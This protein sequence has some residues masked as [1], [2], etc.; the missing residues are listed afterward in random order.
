MRFGAQQKR[1]VTK[2]IHPNGS[3]NFLAVDGS[4]HISIRKDFREV[5]YG[6][7]R[8]DGITIAPPAANGKDQVE[9]ALEGQMEAA[10]L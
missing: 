9:T 10:L 3:N 1:I 7:V 2:V 6:V 8:K 4:P 5:D